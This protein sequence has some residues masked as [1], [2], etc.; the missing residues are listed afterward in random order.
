MS[1]LTVQIYNIVS[2]V[3]SKLKVQH[4]FIEKPTEAEALTSLQQNTVQ[5]EISIGKYKDG[6]NQDVFFLAIKDTNGVTH[7][8][9]DTVDSIDTSN[10]LLKTTGGSPQTIDSF[11]M[12]NFT[13]GTSPTFT[14]TQTGYFGKGP[15][16]SYTE[17]QVM[18]VSGPVTIGTEQIYSTFLNFT[19]NS[20]LS[21]TAAKGSATSGQ[22]VRVSNIFEN[23]A[24]DAH[25]INTATLSYTFDNYS[26]ITSVSCED[27][28]TYSTTS[29]SWE[30]YTSNKP[31]DR[32]ARMS[33]VVA[34]A[35]GLDP[36]NVI[37]KDTRVDG[38]FQEINTIF[39]STD[40]NT[41]GDFT[42]TSTFSCGHVT[43]PFSYSKHTKFT[44]NV[45]SL[46][47]DISELSYYLQLQRENPGNTNFSGVN[48][49]CNVRLSVI[50]SD[51]ARSTYK[52]RCGFHTSV[53]AYKHGLSD[54]SINIGLYTEY[55][56]V[57]NSVDLYTE[58]KPSDRFV[59][60]TDVQGL[61]NSF[62]KI[63]P[64]PFSMA[65]FK[66]ATTA[67]GYRYITEAITSGTIT[68]FR[69]FAHTVGSIGTMTVGIQ[70]YTE[71]D[72]AYPIRTNY[73]GSATSVSDGSFIT[74]TLTTP[75]TVTAGEMYS[76]FLH[77]GTYGTD[78]MKLAMVRL[79]YP[80]SNTL[81]YCP[82]RFSPGGSYSS[83]YSGNFDTIGECPF[84][85]LLA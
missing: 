44:N 66:S 21:A 50:D 80:V 24:F 38:W 53:V 58:D 1:T 54:E 85:E 23:T 30:K 10:F 15:W 67:N 62:V 49:G 26:T 64:F 42:T 29:G 17:N 45:N 19:V 73:S 20:S 65:T 47:E 59:R 5:N 61:T 56:R 14:C 28:L 72:P 4:Y 27:I 8:M 37:L 75:F 40:V 83:A 51:I 63:A 12:S 22:Q 70:G 32:F 2:H 43:D 78:T 71:N 13:Y 25:F 60:Y 82:V 55:S 48:A 79:D 52:V 57:T 16:F 3:L 74:V 36:N 7:K 76:V 18:L 34:A 84:I 11:I 39:D 9:V 33:D 69:V 46:S 41:Y 31:T 35:N 6:L 68:R 81:V 77:F